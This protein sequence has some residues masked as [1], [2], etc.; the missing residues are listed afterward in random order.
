M[1]VITEDFYDED[2][3]KNN[4]RH[5][6][7]INTGAPCRNVVHYDDVTSDMTFLS[8]EIRGCEIL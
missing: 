1:F 7:S 6:S 4:T 3:L 8:S 5:T 2:A